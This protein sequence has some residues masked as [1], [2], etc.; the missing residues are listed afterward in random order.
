MKD[1]AAV[2]AYLKGKEYAEVEDI[3]AEA[4]AEQLRV[5]PLIAELHATGKLEI[6]E[7]EELGSP[8]KVRLIND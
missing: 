8:K 7:T 1:M 3:M 5:Y 2:L 6:L 4:G